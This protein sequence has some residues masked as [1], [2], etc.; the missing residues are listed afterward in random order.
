[1]NNLLSSLGIPRNQ[2]REHQKRNNKPISNQDRNNLIRQW[3]IDISNGG[4]GH[5]DSGN[6]D[7]GLS[8]A[9]KEARNTLKRAKENVDMA[10]EAEIEARIERE[11]AKK[12]RNRA[13]KEYE[14]SKAVGR[15]EKEKT[16]HASSGEIRGRE[17]L[18]TT[19][20]AYKAKKELMARAKEKKERATEEKRKAR[21]L[22][23]ELREAEEKEGT[24]DKY[25]SGNRKGGV[26]G[27][28]TR[29]VVE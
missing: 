27:P 28:G 3:Q 17:R 13:R 20:K 26:A 22:L 14:K 10:T 18:E 19:E 1:M 9:K 11:E 16:G 8:K 21:E 4:K 29:E 6:G 12:T 7:P 24:D 23:N 25:S 2:E 15:A 5:S